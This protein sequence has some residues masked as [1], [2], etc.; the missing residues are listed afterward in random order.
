MSIGRRHLPRQR[1][2]IIHKPTD[3]IHELIRLAALQEG[4]LPADLFGRNLDLELMLLVAHGRA[5]GR[6]HLGQIDLIRLM[7][8]AHPVLV[9]IGA[10]A[11]F[12]I[13]FD[14]VAHVALEV[15]FDVDADAPVGLVVGGVDV[16]VGE[17]GLDDLGELLAGLL[18]VRDADF[19]LVGVAG[20]RA[21]VQ[22]CRES[23]QTVLGEFEEGVGFP[24]VLVVHPHPCVRGR[25]GI[26]G[27]RLG[28]LRGKKGFIQEA[29]ETTMLGL[30]FI[31]RLTCCPGRGGLLRSWNSRN[32]S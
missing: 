4:A 14:E 18:V 19:H 11:A 20:V 16:H 3:Q 30:I 25:G 17:A 8:V 29:V 9:A 15:H 28:S 7:A 22:G 24:G 2:D 23:Q 10:A 26:L 27:G 12:P 32:W 13:G 31:S 1:P 5:L 21:H 6:G